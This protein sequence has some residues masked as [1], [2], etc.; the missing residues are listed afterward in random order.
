M[1]WNSISTEVKLFAISRYTI[2]SSIALLIIAAIF[3]WLHGAIWLVAS[4]SI[5]GF[6][7]CCISWIM[8]GLFLIFRRPNLAYAWLNG[9]NPLSFSDVSWE[10][11]SGKQRREVYTASMIT[12][13][14][15]IAF[16]VWVISE[17]LISIR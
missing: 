16:I 9:R 3:L 8:P 15:V 11:L 14:A 6:L 1:K 12:F 17:K 10:L 2:L 7:L 5:I 4:L 13:I